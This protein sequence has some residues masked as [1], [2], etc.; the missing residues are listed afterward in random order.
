LRKQ[1]RLTLRLVGAR[2]AR[3]LNLNYRGL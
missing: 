1:A 2:E 3:L